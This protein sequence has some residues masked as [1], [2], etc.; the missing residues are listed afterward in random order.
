MLNIIA[1]KEP[2]KNVINVIK[3]IYSEIQ[4]K[5]EMKNEK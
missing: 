4:M 5:N 2:T 3:S 1:T